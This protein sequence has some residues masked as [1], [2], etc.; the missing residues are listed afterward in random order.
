MNNNE[1]L[2]NS[3]WFNS[4]FR[5]AFNNKIN[6]LTKTDSFA[7]VVG[8][9]AKPMS[10]PS[11]YNYLSGK[12]VINPIAFFKFCELCKLSPTTRDLIALFRNNYKNINTI[13][14]EEDN[15]ISLWMFTEFAA[16]NNYTSLRNLAD[17]YGFP[18]F[19]VS[20]KKLLLSIDKIVSGELNPNSDKKIIKKTHVLKKN[21]AT[22]EVPVAQQAPSPEIKPQ[23]NAHILEVIP[24]AAPI[25]DI[26]GS[27]WQAPAGRIYVVT[28]CNPQ[29]LTS[30]FFLVDIVDGHTHSDPKPFAELFIPKDFVRLW[31]GTEV[32]I[33]F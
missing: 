17:T 6:E 3:W 10:V 5:T 23:Y 25:I 19:T 29:D 33:V 8:D 28:T 24:A 16:I 18:D 22:E 11:Y 20:P 1:P 26:L 4:D 2:I 9:L 14:F 13:W 31:P 7:K 12:T 30:H 21:R 15:L 27:H 32:R